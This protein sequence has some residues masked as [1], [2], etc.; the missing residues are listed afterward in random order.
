MRSFSSDLHAEKSTRLCMV[1][2]SDVMGGSISLPPPL[3]LARSPFFNAYFK[4]NRHDSKPDEFASRQRSK[5]CWRKIIK[6]MRYSKRQALTTDI[7]CEAKS[8][9]YYAGL[10]S[11]SSAMR[12][13]LRTRSKPFDI[14]ALTH[15][16]SRS[17]THSHWIGKEEGSLDLLKKNTV[18]LFPRVAKVRRRQMFPRG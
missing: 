1:G 2:K 8:S 15:T 10:S 7:C 5:A 4:E 16:H 17:H 11:L 18:L 3:P 13:Q 12:E 9:H 6:V 14:H